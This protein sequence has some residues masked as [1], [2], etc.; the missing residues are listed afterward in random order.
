MFFFFCFFPNTKP[1]SLGRSKVEK[2]ILEQEKQQGNRSDS[3]LLA[4]PYML[5]AFTKQLVLLFFTQSLS[6]APYIERFSLSSGFLNSLWMASSEQW[7][8]WPVCDLLPCKV[9]LIWLALIPVVWPFPWFWPSLQKHRTRDCSGL[10]APPC[11]KVDSDVWRDE[12]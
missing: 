6:L 11:L 8:S 2:T 4:T 5:Q 7:L 12:K 10:R 9:P 3:K 1:R